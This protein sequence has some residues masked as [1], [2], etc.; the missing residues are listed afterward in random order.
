MENA[1]AI[2][3]E[4]ARRFRLITGRPVEP[5]IDDAGKLA[6]LVGVAPTLA[7][8]GPFAFDAAADVAVEGDRLAQ[9]AIVAYGPISVLRG[10]I[11]HMGRI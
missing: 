1:E 11:R 3:A 9:E 2:A 8:L 7:R 10:Q 5:E 6:L 4:A